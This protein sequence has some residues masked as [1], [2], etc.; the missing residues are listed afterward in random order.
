MVLKN[1]VNSLENWLIL[2]LAQEINK[3][4][5][6]YL[7]VPESK[8]NLKNKTQKTGLTIVGSVG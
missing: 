3:I 4:S 7:A 2:E 5:L 6:R 8:E 1:R